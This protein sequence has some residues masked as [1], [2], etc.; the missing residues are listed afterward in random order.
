MKKKYIAPYME[1]ITIELCSMLTASITVNIYKETVG[2]KESLS[3]ERGNDRQ[4]GTSG[5]TNHSRC[6]QKTERHLARVPFIFCSHRILIQ[7]IETI[8]S[9]IKSS[10]GVVRFNAAK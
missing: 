1:T 8:Y 5:M 9:K 6:Q 7:D 4:W 10:D 3:N 2:A